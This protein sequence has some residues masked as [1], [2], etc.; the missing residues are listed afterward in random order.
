M[1]EIHSRTKILY[2]ALNVKDVEFL[3]CKV[4]SRIIL[5]TRNEERTMRGEVV[6][7]CREI[8]DT[9]KILGS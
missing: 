5:Q 9:N 7:L 2:M 8:F 6:K 4:F 1:L 3:L